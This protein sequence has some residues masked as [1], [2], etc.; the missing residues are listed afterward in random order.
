MHIF[1]LRK[2]APIWVFLALAL[3]VAIGGERSEKLLKLVGDDVGLCVELS[4]LESEVP[5]MIRSPLAAR[6]KSSQLYR[7]WLESDDYK[8]LV[9]SRDSIEKD[10]GRPFD[11][12][13]YELLGK[14][15]VV[16][17][18]PSETKS[19]EAVVLTE[20]AGDKTIDWLLESWRRKKTYTIEALS[21]RG[22]AYFRRAHA[23]PKNTALETLYYLRLGRIFAVSD[24]ETMIRRVIDLHL[25]N[26]S[27]PAD[28]PNAAAARDAQPSSKRRISAFAAGPLAELRRACIF[29]SACV[30]IV[31][32]VVRRRRRQPG[33]TAPC[34]L[35]ETLQGDRGGLA[36]RR[37]PD[38]RD[39]PR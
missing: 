18:Y 20:M 34:R 15:V 21:H 17:V 30:R 7:D 16:A 27:P 6:V 5:A 4:Q 8:K 24:K 9:R 3:R 2:L 28:K 12:L 32:R 31:E 14:S 33:A 10:A 39:Q 29:Q 1:R 26:Q 25:A 36:L 19:L 11:E 38:R 37:R 13:V 22:Q 23:M 35:L